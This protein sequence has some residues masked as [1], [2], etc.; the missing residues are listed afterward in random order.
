MIRVDLR[1]RWAKWMV[2][3]AIFNSLGG[4]WMIRVDFRGWCP[5]WRVGGATFDSLG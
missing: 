4:Y 3:W 5:T 2:G 1:G